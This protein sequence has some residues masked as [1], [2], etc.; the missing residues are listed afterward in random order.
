MASS[1]SEGF[2]M[3]YVRDHGSSGYEVRIAIYDRPTGSKIREETHTGVKDLSLD[4][5]VSI[6][7]IGDREIYMVS[8]KPIQCISKK[9]GELY[10]AG[11]AERN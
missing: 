8:S 11:V 7:K 4:I 5:T 9:P 1:L 10:I 2:S 6:V 3:I